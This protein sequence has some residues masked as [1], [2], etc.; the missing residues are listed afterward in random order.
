M[1]RVLVLNL[2]DLSLLELVSMK[3]KCWTR[4]FLISFSPFKAFDFSD[5]VE[6]RTP[7]KVCEH[8]QY[9]ENGI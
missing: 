6:S 8:W 1:P 7:W 5:T 3:G 9:V 4:S 2:C